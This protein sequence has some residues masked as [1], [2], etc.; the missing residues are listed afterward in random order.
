MARG[1][2]GAMADVENQLADRRLVAVD[3]PAVGRERPAGDAVS[4]A[5][6]LEAGNPV[7]VGFVRPFDRHLEL[8]GEDTRRSAMINVAVGQQDLFDGDLG[9]C[10]RRP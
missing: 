7:N 3:Q 10:G 4:S 8:C 5:V 2:A 6:F 9:L 1:V